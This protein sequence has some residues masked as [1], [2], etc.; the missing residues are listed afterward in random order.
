MRPSRDLR[1]LQSEFTKSRPRPRPHLSSLLNL[2]RHAFQEQSAAIY[3][4]ADF[5]YTGRIGE[6]T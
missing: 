5:S 6:V 1:A 2:E 3:A 4:R